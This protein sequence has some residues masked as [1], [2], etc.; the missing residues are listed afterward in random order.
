MLFRSV[1]LATSGEGAD[2]AGSPSLSNSTN[3]DSDHPE[4]AD[5]DVCGK[6]F[7]RDANLPRTAT[8]S[9]SVASCSSPP[10]ACAVYCVPARATVPLCFCVREPLARSSCFL[11]LHHR[12]SALLCRRPPPSPLLLLCLPSPQ[13]HKQCGSMTVSAHKVLGAMP[14]MVSR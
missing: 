10:C 2:N 4:Q 12:T 13:A 1:S 11:R 3:D 5:G 9:P 7:K 14:D 8:V 6:A